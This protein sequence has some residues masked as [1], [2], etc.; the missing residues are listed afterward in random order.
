VIAEAPSGAK[1]PLR[2]IHVTCRYPLP[3]RLTFLTLA[4]LAARH[5]S[6]RLRL[7]GGCLTSSSGLLQP[8]SLSS[9]TPVSPPCVFSG[10]RAGG[11][12]H[13]AEPLEA[14][15]P[16]ECLDGP[17]ACLRLLPCVGGGG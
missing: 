1:A 6:L 4:L 2:G 17:G 7:T 15:C 9:E 10:T 5:C 11:G 16:M 3:L 14:P 13:G 8:S 12:M